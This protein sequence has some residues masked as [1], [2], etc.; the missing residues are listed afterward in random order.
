MR[1][2]LSLIV[3]LIWLPV[4]IVAVT[5]LVSAL[6]RPHILL[7]AAIYIVFGVLWALPFRGLFRGVGREDPD[8]P[9]G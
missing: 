8:N 5:T 3:L 7:E 9:G 1:K 2:R 6:D 4:Y